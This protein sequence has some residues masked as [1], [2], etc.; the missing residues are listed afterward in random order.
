MELLRATVTR[1]TVAA[2]LKQLDTIQDAG[3]NG[4]L[5]LPGNGRLEVTNLGKIYFP[6][7]KLTKGDVF[8]HYVRVAP[9]IGW[10]LKPNCSI[11]RRTDSI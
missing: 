9:G 6:G 7:L 3:G 2:L 1:R 8:R 10:P 11:T 5:D 4:I